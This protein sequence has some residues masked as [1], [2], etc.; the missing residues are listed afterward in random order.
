MYGT[1]SDRCLWSKIITWS[2][3]IELF[4]RV[5]NTRH[6]S[7]SNEAIVVFFANIGSET[8]LVIG[9]ET[10]NLENNDL[11]QCVS[12]EKFI[13]WIF[14][15]LHSVNNQFRRKQSDCWETADLK[16]VSSNLKMS[17]TYWWLTHFMF[18]S[19]NQIRYQHVAIP[20]TPTCLRLQMFY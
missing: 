7:N 10:Q 12:F 13:Q 5:L 18:R 8:N 6:K 17:M 4:Q 14:K 16:K 1:F 15:A 2:T 20:I 9:S 11:I 3:F 19:M